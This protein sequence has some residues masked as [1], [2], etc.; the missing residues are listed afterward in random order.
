[1]ILVTKQIKQIFSD[2]KPVFADEGNLRNIRNSIQKCKLYNHLYI[3]PQSP[4]T[5]HPK[6]IIPIQKQESCNPHNSC[7]ISLIQTTFSLFH[8]ATYHESH[9]GKA[10]V[11]V[12]ATSTM[13]TDASSVISRAVRSG[14]SQICIII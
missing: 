11:P 14:M 3:H 6:T 9:L 1:M 13:L 5:L 12:L 7:S 4:F 8:I 10:S 2:E